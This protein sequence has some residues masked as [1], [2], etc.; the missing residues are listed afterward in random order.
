MVEK[1]NEVK[2]NATMDVATL[3]L[4]HDEISAMT[5]SDRIDLDHVAY[6][7]DVYMKKHRTRQGGRAVPNRAAALAAVKAAQAWE[8]ATWGLE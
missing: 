2:G 5:D 8:S 3:N 7:L 4:L 6:A 1:G